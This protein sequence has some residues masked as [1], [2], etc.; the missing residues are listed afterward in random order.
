MKNTLLSLFKINTL[1]LSSFWYGRSA[2]T[3]TIEHTLGWSSSWTNKKNLK[4]K[5]MKTLKRRRK[6]EEESEILLLRKKERKLKERRE[7][8]SRKFKWVWNEFSSHPSPLF[9]GKDECRNFQKLLSK[10]PGPRLK[11]EILFK[12]FFFTKARKDDNI[13]P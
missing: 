8:D 13:K 12:F 3:A 4:K 11:I 10:S 5:G 2:Y 1:L 7:R 9:I 6:E